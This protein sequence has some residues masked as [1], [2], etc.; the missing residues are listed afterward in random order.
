MIVF[1]ILN[2]WDKNRFSRPHMQARD[3]ENSA[4]FSD[5]EKLSKSSTAEFIQTQRS[6]MPFFS[7]FSLTHRRR[8]KNF[9]LFSFLLL[10]LLS[11]LLLSFRKYWW[12][13]FYLFIDFFLFSLLPIDISLQL[14][15]LHF[16]TRCPW[17][18]S[19]CV[20]IQWKSLSIPL[21]TTQN[22]ISNGGG[23]LVA[24]GFIL[25]KP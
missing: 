6:I 25:I 24:C 19:Q 1:L 12:N 23:S 8:R 18:G 22:G 21:G 16:G 3:G 4:R 10:R 5:T 13:Y 14:H 11:R 9:S 20:F 17:N 7:G 2:L 15:F